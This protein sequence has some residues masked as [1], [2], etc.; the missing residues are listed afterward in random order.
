MRYI[1]WCQVQLHCFLGYVTGRSLHSCRQLQVCAVSRLRVEK[2]KR[3]KK[4]FWTIMMR[5]TKRVSK[6]TI[7]K[8]C[9]FFLANWSFL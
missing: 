1:P 8:E 9:V 5:K 4:A 6:P 3:K 2:K 7:F